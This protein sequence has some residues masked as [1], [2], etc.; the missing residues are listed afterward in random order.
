MRRASPLLVVALLA[1]GSLAAGLRGEGAS[2]SCDT[3][4]EQTS[5]GAGFRNVKDFG[6]KGDGRTDDTAA[7]LAALTTGRTPKFTLS[8]PALVY[9]PAGNYLVR[10]TLPLYMMTHLVGN[11]KC[12]PTITLMANSGASYAISGTSDPSG[13]HTD[14]F[15]KSIQHLNIAIEPE[16]NAG[17]FAIHW[18]VAQATSIRDVSINATGAKGGLFCEN[19]GGGFIGDLSIVGGETGMMIGGQQWTLRNL[20]ISGSTSS[21]VDL[22][23]NWG[24][25]FLASTFSNCPTGISFKGDA[26]T[27]LA[28]VDS[29]FVDVETGISTDWPETARGVVLDRVSATRVPIVATGLPGSASGT[30]FIRAWRQ[31]YG[32]QGTVPVQP[33]AGQAMLPPFRP[34]EAQ[35]NRGRPT[36]DGMGLPVNAVADAG[37]K[38]DGKADDTPC[39]QAALN[40]SSAERSARAEGAAGTRFVFLPHGTYRITAPL[41]VPAGTTLVGEVLSIIAVDGSAPAF[42]G[43]GGSVT[44]AL[45]VGEGAGPPVMLADLTI[46]TLS[47]APGA[48]LV[49]WAASQGSAVF[50]VHFRLYYAAF[51]QWHFL[52]GSS[53]YVENSW[54]WTADHNVDSGAELQVQ[55][56]NG[57]LVQGSNVSLY[58]TAVEHNIAYNYNFSGASDVVTAMMQTET[59]YWQQ[60]QSAW[61]L[62][63][64]G[65]TERLTSYASGFYS[66][67]FGG[68]HAVAR[69]LP[70]STDVNLFCHNVV[71]SAMLLEAG[72]RAVSNATSAAQKTFSS[73]LAADINAVA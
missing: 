3:W 70:G 41:A 12:R 67:F 15:Y 20:S 9:L 46:T 73:F 45:V 53:A 61:G 51:G 38:A 62:T 54:G 42:Q 47:D 49:R 13:E 8:T 69:L 21:C 65:G 7:L 16:G 31:S 68:Q 56:Q 14:N 5:H 35:P 55:V 34:D 2:E 43:K 19:G 57:W 18:A 44:A 37:C 72:S 11:Y 63:V 4:F 39:L 33:F 60:P 71:G 64:E 29:F 6:A 28:V 10:E 50:D 66:W 40:G 17:V 24:F 25:A 26:V 22:L 36:L 23:W 48:Q 59:P 30:T 52:P 32:F 58:G 1:S 27:S